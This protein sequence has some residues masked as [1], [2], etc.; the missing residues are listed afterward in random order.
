MRVDELKRVLD[1]LP[2]DAE[3][4]GAEGSGG[5]AEILLLEDGTWYVLDD[6]S[7]ETTADYEQILAVAARE[8]VQPEEGA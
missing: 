6:G 8:N 5:S 1:V 4:F 3:V 2:P 7:G